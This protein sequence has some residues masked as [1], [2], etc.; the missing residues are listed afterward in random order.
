MIDHG[1]VN[2]TRFGELAKKQHE[3]TTKK[4]YVAKL[5]TDGE[6]GDHSEVLLAADLYHTPIHVF[7]I[8]SGQFVI[9]NPTDSD[10][11]RT[12]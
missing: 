5:R 12:W 7:N 2:W 10:R 4:E 9:E 3:V 11:V 8:Q 6:Y 1:S